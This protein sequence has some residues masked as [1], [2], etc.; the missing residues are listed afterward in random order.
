MRPEELLPRNLTLSIG[1]RVPPAVTSTLA[2][3]KACPGRERGRAPAAP[4]STSSQAASNSAGS[5]RRPIPCSPLAARRP[6]PGGMTCTPRSRNVS[7]LARTAGC[8]YMWLFIAGATSTGQ[9][10][11]SAQLVSRLSARPWASLAIVLAE[12]G[13]IRYRSACATSSRWLGGSCAGGGWSG[14][15]PRA[16]SRSNSLASTGAPLRAANDAAPT[17]RRLAVVCTT[18]TTCPPAVARRTNSSAL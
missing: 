5:A 2:P 15:A 1:S 12:A 11:A 14:N 18:R 10:A 9:V 3:L 6:L 13:A 8:S 16:G 17:K 7:R 4:A